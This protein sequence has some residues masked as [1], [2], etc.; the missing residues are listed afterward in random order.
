VSLGQAIGGASQAGRQAQSEGLQ[1]A[2]QAQLMKARVSQQNSPYGAIQP[3]KFTPESLAKFG[4]T[5]KYSDLELRT[6]GTMYGRYNPGDFTPESWAQFMSTNDP[7]V[8]ERYVA[9]QAAT[10]ESIGGGLEVVQPSRTGGPTR[11]EAISTPTAEITA[12]ADLKEAESRAGE[13][14]K[15][16]GDLD[17]KAPAKESFKIAI[18]NLRS[19]I[20]TA[21][22]GAV[23]GPSGTIFDYGDKKLFNSRVQQL[24]TDLRTVYRIPGEGTLSDQEQAQYGLQLPSTDNPPEVNAQI[25]NDLEART[26][27]RLETPINGKGGKDSPKKRFNPATG[28]IE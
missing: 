28:R 3:D 10:I 18:G 11:R 9:P 1:Q 27:A 7:S 8:L 12:A 17:A 26:K 5:G 13:V 2:L 19:S 14:G 23:A 20:G 6:T 24:S 22:Q 15:A 4:E 21:M 25:L 16:T